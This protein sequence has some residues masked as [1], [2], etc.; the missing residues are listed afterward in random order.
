MVC[1]AA[2]VVC[3]VTKCLAQCASGNGAMKVQNSM[4]LEFILFKGWIAVACA[5]RGVTVG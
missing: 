4:C 1:S 3:V 5:L 2:L